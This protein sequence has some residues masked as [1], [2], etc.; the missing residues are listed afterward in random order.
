[1]LT[2]VQTTTPGNAGKELGNQTGAGRAF[3]KLPLGVLV[4]SQETFLFSKHTTESSPWR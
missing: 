2:L 1:M 3:T 4:D